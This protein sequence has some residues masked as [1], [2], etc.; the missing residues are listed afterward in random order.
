MLGMS[1][2]LVS[3][4]TMASGLEWA[5]H[6]FILHGGKLYCGGA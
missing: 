4:Y 3:W 1:A 6:K 2:W 5:V